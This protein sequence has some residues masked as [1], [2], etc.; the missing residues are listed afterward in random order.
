MAIAY[1]FDNIIATN[2]PGE[3]MSNPCGPSTSTRAYMKQ[4]HAAYEP[5]FKRNVDVAV[6][7]VGHEDLSRYKLVIVPG[8]YLLD[9][10]SRT[11]LRAY[12]EAGGT[13]LMTAQSAKVDDH[14]QWF[15][16]RRRRAD[17][18]VRAAHQRVLRHG[19][20][21]DALRQRRGRQ[22]SGAASVEVLEPATA[23]VLARFTNVEGP[24]PALTV[25]C[26]RQR[27]AIY[28]ATVAQA[29]L[30]ALLYERLFTE[31]GITPGLRTPEGVSARV[32]QG[33]F[34]S[35]P[36]TSPRTCPSRARSGP[37]ERPDVDGHACCRALGAELLQAH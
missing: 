32:V 3:G 19:R 27:A 28:L 18:C 16:R 23:E 25:N 31:L 36:P 6:L 37:L 7:H 5:L 29:L 8:M 11:K 22:A 33:R 13:V 12:V 1:A 4:A 30:L 21:A 15:R 24:T 10:A 26:F 34:T 14:N 17:R 9:E 2:L 35:T 20:F